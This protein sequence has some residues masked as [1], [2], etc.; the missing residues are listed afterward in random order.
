MNRG[1]GG[2]RRLLMLVMLLEIKERG[3]GRRGSGVIGSGVRSARN[4]EKNSRVAL[5]LLLSRRSIRTIKNNIYSVCPTFQRVLFNG[6]VF[7]APLDPSLSRKDLELGQLHAIEE[8]EG[9][10]GKL[11]GGIVK[12]DYATGEVRIVSLFD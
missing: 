12:V 5:S 6:H 1:L 3:K 9:A 4:P 8:V 11:T 7:A 10:K 2:V